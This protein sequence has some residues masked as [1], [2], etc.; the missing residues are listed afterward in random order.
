MRVLFDGFWWVRGPTSNRQ[1]MREFIRAWQ[2]EFPGDEIFVAVPRVHSSAARAQLPDRVGIVTTRLRPQG[3]SAIFELPFVALG[4]KADVTITHNFTPLIGPSAVFIHDV[5]FVTNPEWFTAK[6]RAYFALMPIT[7]KRARWVFTSSTSEANRIRTATGI[8]RPVTAVGLGLSGEL[9][10]ARPARPPGLTDVDGFLL[11]VGR[12]NIRKNLEAVIAGSIESGLLTPAFPLLIVGE[13]DGASA[14]LSE[15]AAAAAESG[16]IRF[17]GFVDDGQLA[18]LY[19]HASAFLLL[20]LD[21]GFGLPTL[22]AVRYGAPVIASDIPV[23]REILGTR[24]RFVAPRDHAALAQAIRDA[25]ADGRAAPASIEDL[26]YS[27]TLSVRRM[28]DA[29]LQA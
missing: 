19:S 22:E 24:A 11:S 8:R 2:M 23:F 16:A 14:K 10:R 15:G 7:A 9:D 12:L 18:W 6:E 27:W 21:E 13:P 25:T 26:G 28:R 29:I 1:V 3:L 17:L 4:V 5:M 20:S